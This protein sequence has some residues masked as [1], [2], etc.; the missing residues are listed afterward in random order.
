MSERK[1]DYAIHSNLPGNPESPASLG[2]KFVGTLDA[3]TNIDPS[4]FTNWEIMDFPAQDSAPLAAV[5]SHIGAMIEKNVDRN[6]LGEA[7]PSHG[8]HVVAFTGNVSKSR[9]I[10]LRINAGGKINSGIWLET[11]YWRVAAD[12]DIVTYRIFKSAL[13]AIEAFWPSAWANA[14][15]RRVGHVAVPIDD[16][17]A[18]G[19]QAVRIDSPRQVPT[20]PSFPK[21]F[22][23]PWLAYLSAKLAADLKLAPEILTERTPDG[24]LLMTATED[25]ID[26]DNPEHLRRARVLAETMI[27]C[28]RRSSD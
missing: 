11:G 4:I 5:R 14:Y 23:I 12:P 22:H 25:R 13:L 2:A 17:G 10:N 18:G 15:V 3:L 20:D 6:Q 26:P 27:A 7:A 19:V 9:H 1:F 8:Y 16:V 28:T 24:G 21:G